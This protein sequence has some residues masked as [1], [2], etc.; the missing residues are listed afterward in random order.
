[1]TLLTI[2]Y[3]DAKSKGG[4]KLSVSDGNFAATIRLRAKDFE[5]AKARAKDVLGYAPKQWNVTTHKLHDTEV[6]TATSR[7]SD[8]ISIAWKAA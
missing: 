6:A 8:L 1:M 7:K 5:D 2:F 3:D 4:W